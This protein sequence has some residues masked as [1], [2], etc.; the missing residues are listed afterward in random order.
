MANIWHRW[1]RGGG[2]EISPWVGF[3][4][5]SLYLAAIIAV[6]AAAF[7]VHR[8]ELRYT[9]LSDSRQWVRWLARHLAHVSS[10]PEAVGRELLQISREPG[11]D[12]CGIIGG[13]GKYKLH[14]D[15]IQVGKSGIGVIWT[16]EPGQAVRVGTS[17]VDPGRHVLSCRIA[18]P[19]GEDTG[20]DLRVGLSPIVLSWRESDL[21]FW[22]GYVLLVVLG[23]FLVAYRLFRRQ[24]RPLAVIRRQLLGC[25]QSVSQ[26]IAALRLND[27]FDQMSASWNRLIEFVAEMQ[28]QVRHNKLL[29][30][31]TSAMDGYRSERLT[32]I[33]M[34]IPF[35]V[36][37]V[38]GE[39]V[40][41]FA[42]R[43][44]VGMLGRS[45]ESLDNR[46]L[47]D[48][49][50]ESVRVGLLSPAAGRATPASGARWLDHAIK[51]PHGEVTL[52]FW[53][54][55]LGASA[56]GARNEHILFVQDVTQ[57]KEAERARDRFLYHV[58]HELRTPLTNIRAYAETLSQ[59]VIDDEQMIRECYNVIMGETRRL[60]QLVEDILNVSQLEVGSAR[61]EIGEVA[62]DELLRKVVQDVQA[63]A[64]EKNLDLVLSIPA[65]LPKVRGD[66]ERLAVVFVNLIGNA[67]KYTPDSGRIDVSCN[68]ENERVRITVADT[69]MG[70]PQ[71][72]HERIF[73]KFYRV[74]DPRIAKIPG[75]GLGL[76]I[77]KE[78][79]R[80]HS[81][82]VFVTSAPEKG[83]TFTMLLPAIPIDQSGPAPRP[84]ARRSG[85]IK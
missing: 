40:I 11:I 48:F 71:K 70:I 17:I 7:F 59:G 18:S 78:T 49:L 14:S 3:A 24:V 33:L 46:P 62:V 22:S 20:E 28:E 81:G 76:A 61:L 82:A 16:D 66:R 27:S 2:E 77:V 26:N 8:N 54:I 13:D 85:G 69:G 6:G 31:V 4:F 56:A 55:A 32:Q 36:L 21:L 30:D 44:G 50:D 29:T 73:E 53:P 74:D 72:D 45:G 39:G 52:R 19:L 34:D 12:F 5:A 38:D 41:S 9:R 1:R 23:L 25:S 58:T 68:T 83:S 65:K 51:R 80:L 67:I 75:T 47:A 57:V 60:N 63:S 64:D 43:A 37:V 15:P 42:N 10:S 84:A 35:G 79:V